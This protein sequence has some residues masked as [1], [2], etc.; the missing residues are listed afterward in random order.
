MEHDYQEFDDPHSHATH[1]T[2]G[3]VMPSTPTYE[4]VIYP[5]VWY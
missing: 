3:L 4:M 1:H 5:L 2:Y